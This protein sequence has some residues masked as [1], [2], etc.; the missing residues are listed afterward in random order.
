MSKLFIALSLIL[1]IVMLGCYAIEPKPSVSTE[2]ASAITVSGAT[3]NGDLKML[4]RASSVKVSF[5]WW[6]PDLG[7]VNLT[8]VQKRESIGGF[9]SDITGLEPGTTYY[10]KAKAEG[11]GTSYGFEMSFTT[12]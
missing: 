1:C 5:E 2:S 12:P 9:S 4:G 7:Y 11:E 10:F 3:L 8:P 6:E